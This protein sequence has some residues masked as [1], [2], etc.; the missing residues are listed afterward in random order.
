[1]TKKEKVLVAIDETGYITRHYENC[2][3]C[4]SIGTVKVYECNFKTWR[5]VERSCSVCLFLERKIYGCR[6]GKN[7]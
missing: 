4:G 3:H 7:D 5:Q 6:P 2:D 1:M